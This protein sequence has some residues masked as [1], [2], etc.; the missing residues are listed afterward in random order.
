MAQINPPIRNEVSCPRFAACC[1]RKQSL[2]MFQ[3]KKEVKSLQCRNKR[4][5][6]V[7]ILVQIKH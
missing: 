5:P 3:T 7:L 1:I 2:T 6:F 4:G